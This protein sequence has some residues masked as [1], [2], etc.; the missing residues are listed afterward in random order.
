V[1][2]RTP[3]EIDDVHGELVDIS[4]GGAAVRFPLGTLPA[5]GLVEFRLPGA[6]QIKMEMV[7]I[8]ALNAEYVLASL[9]ALRTEWSAF[10]AMSLWMF[11]TPRGAIPGLPAGVPVIATLSQ[12]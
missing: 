7:R 10:G 8:R 6:E 1:S 5:S 12:I 2:L 3:I 11:H 9:R 4:V